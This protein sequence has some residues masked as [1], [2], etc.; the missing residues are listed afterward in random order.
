VARYEVTGPVGSGAHSVKTELY[1][2]G[3]RILW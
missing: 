3:I 2:D 1:S